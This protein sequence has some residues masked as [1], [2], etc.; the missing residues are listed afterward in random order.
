M[1]WLTRG[2]GLGW[3]RRGVGCFRRGVGC[4]RRG[5]GWLRRGVGCRLSKGGLPQVTE[6]QTGK[7][8]ITV[9]NPLKVELV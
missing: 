2:M 7:A 1:R 5:V 3:P 4:L 9:S 6:C 8:E